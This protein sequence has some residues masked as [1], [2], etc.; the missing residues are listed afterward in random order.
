LDRA[1]VL[2]AGSFFPSRKQ[3]RSISLTEKIRVDRTLIALRDPAQT[4]P[5]FHRR[6]IVRLA[7]RKSEIVRY[8]VAKLLARHG[9]CVRYLALC[10]IDEGESV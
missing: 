2:P 1:K 10:E 7:R 8:N 3:L 9:C 4:M 5:L 6:Q